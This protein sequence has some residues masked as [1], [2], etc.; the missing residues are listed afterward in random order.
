[1]TPKTPDAIRQARSRAK[2]EQAGGWQVTVMLTNPAAAKLAK[3]M[4]RGE[5]ISSAVNLLLTRSKP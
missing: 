2:R 4:A 5:T 1:M 3:W